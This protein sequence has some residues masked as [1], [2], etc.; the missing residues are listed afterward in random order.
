MKKKRLPQKSAFSQRGIALIL[1]LSLIALASIIAVNLITNHLLL[2]QIA[3]NRVN[4][5]KGEYILK[6]ALNAA[7]ILLS[8]D[9]SNTDGPHDIWAKYKK[10]IEIP[11]SLVGLDAGGVKLA[12]QIQAENSK[13]RLSRLVRSGGRR[14]DT[15]WRDALA[16]LFYN[17]GFDDDKDEVYTKP[18]FKGRHFTSKE[19][20]A[21]L[22]DY[23]DIDKESYEDANFPSGIESQLKPNPFPN[24]GRIQSLSELAVIPGFTEKR[25]RQLEPFLTPNKGGRVNINLAPKEVLMALDEELTEDLVDQIISFR[26]SDSGP[27]AYTNES[28]D[29]TNWT[30]QLENIIGHDLRIKIQPMITVESRWFEI[31]GRVNFSSTTL[32]MRSFV[33]RIN[34]KKPAV[35]YAVQFFQ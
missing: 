20:V 14:V 22:I 29:G 16:R 25:I 1:V 13:I 21:N 15:R 32:Y 12:L 30:L 9:N 7:R 5:V 35:V 6:S 31:I 28:S 19:L 10:G 33:Y 4:T 3:N 18:P 27:F 23:L 2:S 24:N 11:A 34:R 8:E 26:N 17:L